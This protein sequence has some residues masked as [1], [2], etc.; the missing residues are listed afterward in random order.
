M[1][2]LIERRRT[3]ISRT[4]KAAVIALFLAAPL[5]VAW[6]LS[7]SGTILSLVGTGAGTPGNP[8][9]ISSTVRADSAIQNSNLIYKLYSPSGA[10]LLS[11]KIGAPNNMQAGGTFDDA[12]SYSNPPDTGSY[13]VTLCWSTGNAENCDIASSSTGFYSVPTLG[14]TLSVI[15]LALLAVFLHRRRREFARQVA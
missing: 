14:W 5:G 3:W 9:Q 10:L 8:I 12:W 13:T 6:A 1:N 15:S 7:N 11:R 2:L 4:A